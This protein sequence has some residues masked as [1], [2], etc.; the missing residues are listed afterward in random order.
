V[1]TKVD[2][3]EQMLMQP[4]E[5]FLLRGLYEGIRSQNYMVENTIDT[6]CMCFW[7]LRFHDKI[8]VRRTRSGG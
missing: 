8:G 3:N 6:V 7:V 4:L 2:V 1:D 5:D